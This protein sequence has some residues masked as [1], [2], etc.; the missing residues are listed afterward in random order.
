MTPTSG[1]AGGMDFERGQFLLRLGLDLSGISTW[2]ISSSSSWISAGLHIH[3]AQLGLDRAH[4]LAQK[5]LS[6]G[7]I[8]LLLDLVVDAVFQLE[9][10]ELA[11]QQDAQAL[12]SLVGSRISSSSWRLVELE[13][14]QG[15]D[16]VGQGPG[17]ESSWPP[18]RHPRALCAIA[19]PPFQRATARRA[20]GPRCLA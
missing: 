2:R 3:L 9:H 11:G 10:V 20:S 8:D 6:L 14:E 18:R 17:S 13:I 1:A 7:A 4:L 12:Q 16:Q 5:V 15:S 19:A